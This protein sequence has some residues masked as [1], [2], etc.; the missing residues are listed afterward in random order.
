[1]LNLHAA[2]NRLVIVAHPDDDI[3]GCGGSLAKYPNRKT[4]I[5]YL[6]SGDAGSTSHTR[7]EL[8]KIREEE[9]K[10]AAAVLGVTDLVFLRNQDGF[11]ECNKTNCT[12][13]ANL[14]R[15]KQPDIL[16]SHSPWDIHP[17]HQTTFEIT[18]RAIMAAA[19]SGFQELNRA[20]WVTNA[21]LAFE[22]MVPFQKPQLIEDISAQMD[23]KLKA[24][25]QHESQ[26][27]LRCQEWIEGLNKYRAGVSGAGLYAEAFKILRLSSRNNTHV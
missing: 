17:D 22:I 11:L 1:L 3:I 13:L 7:E 14:I 16:Y 9:A 21:F 8:T 4:T 24:L 2:T 5:V 27:N 20:P 19:T 25:Q 10:K 26:K 15:E 6:T 12:T 18:R 23:L